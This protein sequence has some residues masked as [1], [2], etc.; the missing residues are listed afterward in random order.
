M[1]RSSS[2]KITGILYTYLS[3][4]QSDNT[5]CMY[6]TGLKSLKTSELPTQYI[7]HM[8]RQLNFRCQIVVLL[9][10][11]NSVGVYFS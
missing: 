6:K 11:F 2:Y 5:R 4:K 3:E 1:G 8:H 7:A 9:D 10:F